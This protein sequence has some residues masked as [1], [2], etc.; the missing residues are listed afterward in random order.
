[1]IKGYFVEVIY[2]PP[3]NH[4][5]IKSACLIAKIFNKKLIVEMYVSIYDTFVGDRKI[6]KGTQIKP[7]T[8]KANS[9]LKKDVL[10]LKKAEGVVIVYDLEQ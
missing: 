3:M 7:K 10:A 2:L 5:F 4:Q 1:M 8:R 9:M 6:L